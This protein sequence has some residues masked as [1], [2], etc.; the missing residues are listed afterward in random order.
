MI[1]TQT[2][3]DCDQ[4]GH[5]FTDDWADEEEAIQ[6][7]NDTGWQANKTHQYCPNHWHIECRECHTADNGPR[8]RLQYQ[9][10]QIDTDN[11]QQ[12]LCPQCTKGT[13]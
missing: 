6:D 8:H 4:C 13:K 2:T 12:S 10:W 1:Y 5:S 9:G 3:I 11:P 7:A